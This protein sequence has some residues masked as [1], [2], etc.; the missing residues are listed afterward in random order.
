[1]AWPLDWEAESSEEKT[2]LQHL[3]NARKKDEQDALTDLQSQCQS[4]S[5]GLFHQL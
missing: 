4:P 1:M 3:V 5:S 2:Q